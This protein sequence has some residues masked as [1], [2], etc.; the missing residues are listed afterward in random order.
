MPEPYHGVFGPP[1]PP[2]HKKNPTEMERI[3]TIAAGL[4]KHDKGKPIGTKPVKKTLLK[5]KTDKNK[6]AGLHDKENTVP[7]HT[8]KL[9]K[10]GPTLIL[11]NKKDTPPKKDL[12]KD[13]IS[14]KPEIPKQ[15][16]RRKR[17]M[18]V[19]PP[20]KRRRISVRDV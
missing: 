15:V 5:T 11:A 16:I 4:A 6:P 18:T 12:R 1:A 17:I 10:K 7:D 13:P 19:E 20:A 9:T 2:G 8:K 14:S 3:A